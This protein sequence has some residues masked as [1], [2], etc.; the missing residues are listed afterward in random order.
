[1]TMPKQKPGKSKYVKAMNAVKYGLCPYH[2]E[3][4]LVTKLLH[5][6]GEGYSQHSYTCEWLLL[7]AKV[8]SLDKYAH[9]H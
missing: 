7:V 8:P 4:P 5:R 9:A 6:Y 1:M 2:D 3:H